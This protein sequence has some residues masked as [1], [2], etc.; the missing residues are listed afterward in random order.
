MDDTKES[1][2]HISSIAESFFQPP[3]V[4]SFLREKRKLKINT[5]PSRL[6]FNTSSAGA[7]IRLYHPQ[8]DLKGN[9]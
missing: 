7:I 6:V 9:H 1:K 5:A 8:G 4:M 3:D 2:R